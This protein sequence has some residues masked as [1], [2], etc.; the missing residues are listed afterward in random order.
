MRTINKQMRMS[1]SD[2]KALETLR[3]EKPN[4]PET[5]LTPKEKDI[6]SSL[7]GK[8]IRKIDN[9]G[10]YEALYEMELHER[11]PSGPRVKHHEAK[12]FILENLLDLN[13]RGKMTDK[14]AQSFFHCMIKGIRQSYQHLIYFAYC[15]SL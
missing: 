2:K 3:G 7:Y 4:L 12:R 15:E 10:H 8:Y 6:V 14:Q 1:K 13:H 5:H 9:Q 11:W